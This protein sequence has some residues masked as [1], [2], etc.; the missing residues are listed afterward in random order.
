MKNSNNIT[1]ANLSQGEAEK[2][3]DLEQTFNN[4]FQSEYYFM[5]MKNNI[6]K[7]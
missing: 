4:E 5:V 2:L 1:Y 6:I 3:K 7:S